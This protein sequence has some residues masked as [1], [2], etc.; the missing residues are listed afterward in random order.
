[1]MC[2]LS[3]SKHSAWCI[4]SPLKLQLLLL[5]LASTVIA[6]IITIALKAVTN[7]TLSW[8]ARWVGDMNKLEEEKPVRRTLE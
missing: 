6:T 5:V 8:Y 3:H 1:M 2:Q 7:T 4:E